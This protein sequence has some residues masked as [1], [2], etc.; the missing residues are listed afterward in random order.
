[1]KRKDYHN[2]QNEHTYSHKHHKLHYRTHEKCFLSDSFISSQRKNT[3]RQRHNHRQKDSGT[4]DLHSSSDSHHQNHS[5]SHHS[6]IESEEMEYSHK[7][8]HNSSESRK[9]SNSKLQRKEIISKSQPDLINFY[10]AYI[11]KLHHDAELAYSDTNNHNRLHHKRSHHKNYLSSSSK[12]HN[13]MLSSNSYHSKSFFDSS[14]DNYVQMNDNNSLLK[15]SHSPIN[16]PKY[17]DRK[18]MFTHPDNQD[19]EHF[20]QH[21]ERHNRSKDSVKWIQ[22]QTP[23]DFSETFE[24]RNTLINDNSAVFSL[25]KTDLSRPDIQTIYF[26]NPDGKRSIQ[27]PNHALHHHSNSQKEPDTG[28]LK[29]NHQE[30]FNNGDIN[31]SK[32]K[33]GPI[34]NIIIN[35][36]ATDLPLSTRI[37]SDDEIGSN[38]SGFSLSKLYS[39]LAFPFSR[40]SPIIQKILDPIEKQLQSINPSNR[41]EYIL[42]YAK[43]FIHENPVLAPLSTYN[44]SHFVIFQS[45]IS[46]KRISKQKPCFITAVLTLDGVLRT[47]DANNE[48]DIKGCTFSVHKNVEIEIIKNEKRIFKFYSDNAEKWHNVL[49]ELSHNDSILILPAFL[50]II[51]V[52]CQTTLEQIISP[53]LILTI[54]LLNCCQL[55]TSLA[56]SVFEIFLANKRLDF[57]LRSLFFAEA[58]VTPLHY[59]FKKKTRYSTAM[60]A[61]FTSVGHKWLYTLALN[62]IK[63]KISSS[64]SLLQLIFLAF[65]TIPNKALYIVRIVIML[66]ILTSTNHEKSIFIP[67]ISFMRASIQPYIT[68]YFSESVGCTS[69]LF[70]QLEMHL[71]SPIIVSND[72]FLRLAPFVNDLLRISPKLI[73]DHETNQNSEVNEINEFIKSN[74]E[75]LLKILKTYLESENPEHPVIYSYYQNLKFLL[76]DLL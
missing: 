51:S 58:S 47:N 76:R 64:H 20:L 71:Q 16:T 72:T 21:N 14:H 4:D 52:D 65:K 66:S 36:N 8:Y 69:S 28:I 37:S 9:L 29:C 39:S 38:D 18:V 42:M 3:I 40:M 44:I 68:R 61:L 11:E 41:Q 15:K 5:K 70:A 62:I 49:T 30:I 63:N 12:H 59:L 13:D 67:F 6:P 73:Q 46:Y 31:S 17:Q 33:S 74:P 2:A 27:S 45:L 25:S 26:S 34:F 35:D 55:K 32:E 24:D 60:I 22:E 75:S 7:S 19:D 23:D 54:S 1:M 43:T 50:R 57:L 48:I 56:R 53:N 10:K